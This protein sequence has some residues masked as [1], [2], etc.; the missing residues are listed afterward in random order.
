MIET[1]AALLRA[2]GGPLSVET[3]TF[4]EPGP[5]DVLVRIATAAI[6]HSDLHT[7]AN[8]APHLPMIIGHE[9][10]GI[11]ERV[12]SAVTD[13]AVGQKVALSFVP[14]CG[15]CWA[16]L[17]GLAVECVR[18]SAV[19][20]DGRALDGT[21][22]ATSSSGEE[23]GQM[24]RL[25]AFSERVVVHRDSCVAI[26][27]AIPLEVAALVSCGFLTGAGAVLN[28]AQTRPGDNVVV[29][30]TGGVGLAAIQAAALAGASHVVAVDV[31]E[32]KLQTALRFGA[33]DVLDG[34]DA[35]WPSRAV[36]VADGRGA[37][38]AISCVSSLSDEHVQQLMASVRGGGTAVLVGA[39]R[40][41]LDVFAMGRKTVT[42]TLYGSRDPKADQVRLLEL[43]RAGKFRIEEM[44]SATY[45][46]DDV[47]EAIADLRAGKNIRGVISFGEARS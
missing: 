37:D 33:T 6:C 30:G 35:D 2:P 12:G 45:G 10:S 46:L 3:V 41:M 19:G 44:I 7:V 18:G 31:N 21:F 5:T 40:A 15:S 29:V 11:V 26:G 43:Y 22:K 28:V 42:R 23:V 1:R 20:A 32:E 17:R 25:G 16:C 14:S 4:A 36:D 34:G 39:G 47:N 8:G 38:Q 13:L 24:V 27:D 9:A